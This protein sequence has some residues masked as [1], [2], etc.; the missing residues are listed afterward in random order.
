MPK[1]FNYTLYRFSGYSLSNTIKSHP[2]YS[3]IA[4]EIIFHSAF[5]SQNLQFDSHR[6]RY[7][8]HSL[9]AHSLSPYLSLSASHR[10]FT[11]LYGSPYALPPPLFP[12]LKQLVALNCAIAGNPL[13]LRKM[14]KWMFC[15]RT[16]L[17]SSIPYKIGIE[18][19]KCS[20]NRKRFK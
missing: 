4:V 10:C 6:A 19:N 16:D 11:S 7:V 1:V 2:N 17:R 9:L 20:T 18:N 15:M 5:T 3:W 14:P 12:P 13:P 8:W